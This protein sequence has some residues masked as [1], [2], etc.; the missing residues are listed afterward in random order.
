MT[1]IRTEHLSGWPPV[2]LPGRLDATTVSQARVV[3]HDAVD[4]ADD[5]H[6]DVL[7]RMD[8][9]D[10]LDATGLGVLVGAHRRAV[11]SGRRLVLLGLNVRLVRLLAVTRLDRVLLTAPGEAPRRV[12]L[13]IVATRRPTA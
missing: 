7:V 11:R 9:V 3:L 6:P 5:E 12:P 1:A 10:V 13:R 4:R 8:A 2:A